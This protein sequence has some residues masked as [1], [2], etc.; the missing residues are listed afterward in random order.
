MFH[1]PASRMLQSV[2]NSAQPATQQWLQPPT[3]TTQNVPVAPATQTPQPVADPTSVLSDQQKLATFESVLSEMDEEKQAETT[4]P[5]PTAPQPPAGYSS[6]AAK[7]QAPVIASAELPGGMQYVE[8]EPNPEIPL[9]VKSYLQKVE[10]NPTDLPQE[11]VIAAQQ[12]AAN[13]PR[14]LPQ[15]FK[16]LPITQAQAEAGKKKNP[17]FSIRWLVAFSEKLTEMFKGKAVYRS[18]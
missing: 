2:Q 13:Q 9:E 17:S 3:D 14:N 18:E 12:H 4:Q 1:S 8:S 7:E 15:D 6:G 5:P 10:E 16:V 11:I